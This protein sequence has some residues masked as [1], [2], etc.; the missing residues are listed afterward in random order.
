MAALALRQSTVEM[1]KF[2]PGALALKATTDSEN[3]S[4][5]RAP[6]YSLGMWQGVES[7]AVIT[8][9]KRQ[10]LIALKLAKSILSHL[11]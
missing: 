5:P 3:C 8:T 11:K 4:L 10:M 7:K 1:S 6:V 9:T 2:L